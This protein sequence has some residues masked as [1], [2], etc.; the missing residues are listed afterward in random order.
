MIDAPRNEPLPPDLGSPRRDPWDAQT[1]AGVIT[2]GALL[3]LT[4]VLFG[5]ALIVG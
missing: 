5:W 4:A 2:G 3:L 1:L